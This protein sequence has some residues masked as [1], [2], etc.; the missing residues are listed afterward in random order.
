MVEESAD[1]G[2]T[3]RY[4]FR[5]NWAHGWLRNCEN[6]PMLTCEVVDGVCTDFAIT[7]ID[8]MEHYLGKLRD[9]NGN[10][11]KKTTYGSRKA[12]LFHLFRSTPCSIALPPSRITC[13]AGTV[14]E[15][16]ATTT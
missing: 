6:V 3:Q 10:Y 1:M 5:K 11:L 7:P 2:Y 9:N 4:I 14:E 12:G 8:Y 16:T 13:W 15:F